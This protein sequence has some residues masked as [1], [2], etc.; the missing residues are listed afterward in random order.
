MKIAGSFLLS[1]SRR[2]IARYALGHHHAN[3]HHHHHLVHSAAT[4]TPRLWEMLVAADASTRPKVA[5]FSTKESSGGIRGWMENRRE[6]KEQ[7]KYMEQMER[8][9]NM[10]ELTLEGYR[11]ELNRGLDSWGAKLSFGQTKEIKMAKEVVECISCFIDVLGNN[12]TADD[13]I[14]MDRLQRLKVATAS[15]KSVEDIQIMISQVQNMD[16]MQRTLR[17]RKL[18]GK[19]I[20]PDS[21][22]MQA[23]IKR[24]ALSVMSKTQ[25]EMMKNRQQEA[26]RRMARRRR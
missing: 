10:E 25:K 16:L 2:G 6:K 15:K 3:H 20:P 5:T 1:S 9:S 13:M 17:K 11:E 22:S 26:A 19:P 24:D 8:L 12:A 23:A 14:A 21:Q 18:D 7:E 4:T